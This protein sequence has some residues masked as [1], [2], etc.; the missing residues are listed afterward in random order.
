MAR[1]NNANL[2]FDILSFFNFE[3]PSVFITRRSRKFYEKYR[4]CD[5]FMC[6]MFVVPSQLGQ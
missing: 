2:V 3:L 4:T 5:N 6:K 1:T